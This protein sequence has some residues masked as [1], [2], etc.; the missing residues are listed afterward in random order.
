MCMYSALTASF[1]I[2]SQSNSAAAI[3]Y[4]VAWWGSAP[5]SGDFILPFARS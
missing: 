5:G 1:S 2:T 3:E 4:A